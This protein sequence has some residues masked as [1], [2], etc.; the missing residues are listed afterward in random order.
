MALEDPGVLQKVSEKFQ[1]EMSYSWSILVL[2]PSIALFKN[3]H[4]LYMDF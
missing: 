2:K 4:V 1:V 3:F